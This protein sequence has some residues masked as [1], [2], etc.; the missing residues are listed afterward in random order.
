MNKSKTKELISTK[1]CPNCHR[2]LNALPPCPICG[3]EFENFLDRE[4]YTEIIDFLKR[5]KGSQCRIYLGK[6]EGEQI[7]TYEFLT[8]KQ[9][10]ENAKL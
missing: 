9:V 7:L 2:K 4:S 5:H 8:K 6:K 1:I 10:M 3:T